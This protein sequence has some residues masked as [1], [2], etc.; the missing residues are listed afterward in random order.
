MSAYLRAAIACDPTSVRDQLYEG[1]RLVVETLDLSKRAPKETE[2]DFLPAI[3]KLDADKRTRKQRMQSELDELRQK[4]HDE[5]IHR[6]KA[7]EQ[8]KRDAQRRVERR[9]KLNKELEAMRYREPPPPPKPRHIHDINR[10]LVRERLM[11]EQEA[12]VRDDPLSALEDVEQFLELEKEAWKQQ[13]QEDEEEM[14][15][16]HASRGEKRF[17]YV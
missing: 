11:Q 5:D 15:E 6:Q 3:A 7:E 16:L 14:L 12:T 4:E 10:E 8:T 13:L 2:P 1:N 9:Q 17:Q